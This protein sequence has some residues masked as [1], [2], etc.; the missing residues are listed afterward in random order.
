MSSGITSPP[1][2]NAAAVILAV[3]RRWV[4]ADWRS[5]CMT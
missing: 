5:H 4:A 3:S 1:A 2:E